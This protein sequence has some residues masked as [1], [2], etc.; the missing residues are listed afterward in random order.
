MGADQVNNQHPADQVATVNLSLGH[1]FGTSGFDV[2]LDIENLTDKV[3]EIR[4]GTG[5]GVGAPSY[6]QRRG[7]FVGV[8]KAL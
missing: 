5:V 8:S 2:R 7:V 3:Y 4:D 1:S 6:G